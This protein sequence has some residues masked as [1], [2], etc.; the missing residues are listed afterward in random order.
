MQFPVAG[1]PGRRCSAL[2]MPPF[3][4]R[5]QASSSVSMRLGL[6]VVVIAVAAAQ[7]GGGGTPPDES[8]SASPSP[9]SS[10]S[11]SSTASSSAVRRQPSLQR[12]RLIFQQRHD[13]AQPRRAAAVC[14]LAQPCCSIVA[15]AAAWPLCPW[16]RAR[17]SSAPSS[18]IARRWRQRLQ[19]LAQ[20]AWRRA[21]A[22]L[23]QCARRWRSR[24]QRCVPA[25]RCCLAE[26]CAASG[27]AWLWRN[28]QVLTHS[29]LALCAHSALFCSA[30]AGGSS[31]LRAAQ[32]M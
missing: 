11:S 2:N 23:T 30:F 25:R 14:A 1:A 21:M 18:S 29:E 4:R 19:L 5:S 6:F 32:C 27:V 31:T 13:G 10:A 7:G 15:V 28:S 8:P 26:R 22:A 17:G 20:G 12:H 16:D 24:P 9:T 3:R